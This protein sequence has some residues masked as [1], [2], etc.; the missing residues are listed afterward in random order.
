M[1]IGSFSA[2]R[3]QRR[4]PRLTS[5]NTAV[6]DRDGKLVFSPSDLADYLACE[7]LTALEVRRAGGEKLG[8]TEIDDPTAELIRRK[9]DEHEARYLAQLRAE[10]H[11]VREIAR[12]AEPRETEDAIRAGEADV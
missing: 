2:F 4:R 7:H 12:D 8:R 1:A 10:G 5:D 6:Q 9:G 3:D 11:G